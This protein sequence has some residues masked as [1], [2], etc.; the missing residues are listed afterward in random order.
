MFFN[1]SGGGMP[2]GFPGG[3]PGGASGGRKARGDVD[4]TKFYKLLEVDKNASD[5]EIK[6]AYRKLAIKHHPDKGGD[7]EVFKELSKAYEVLSDKD[8]RST[9]DQ[10]GEEG[11]EGG[12]GGDPS[13]I[14]SA[15]FGGGGG[16]PSQG[17]GRKQKT[18]DVKQEL[19]V[20]L[21][22]IYGGQTKKMAITRQVID[23]DK[24]VK[25][26]Q[27][28]DGKGTKVQIVRMGPMI[29]QSQSQCTQ[30]GGQ[31]KSFST[32]KERQILEVHISKGSPEGHQIRFHEMADERPDHDTG[33]VIF[34][35][36]EQEHAVF[37]R[38]GADLFV[39]RTISLADALCGY[40]LDILHLDGRKLRVKTQPGDIVKPL[41][42]A[43]DPSA[44]DDDNK[45]ANVK[46]Q[47]LQDTDCR[48]DTVAQ[49][50]GSDA[51]ALKEACTGQLQR[52]G[53]DCNCFTISGGN[54]A[55]KTGTRE[56]VM[57]EMFP[58][59]GATTYVQAD[60]N[61]D[62]EVAGRIM[63]CVKGEG[64]PTLKNPFQHGNMFI[65]LNIEFPTGLDVETQKTLR[66]LLPRLSKEGEKKNT[67][68]SS[69]V[70]PK[71][72]KNE[73]ELEFHEIIDMDPVASYES[74]KLNMS[75]G[76]E[77]YDEDEEGGRGG[78]GGAQCQQM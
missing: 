44:K 39:E 24:G 23:K 12:G 3:F 73:D 32:K 63:K 72:F 57:K 75:T 47:V 40:E 21:E 6:K 2:G 13:D 34:I 46:W 18:E 65:I 53:I 51:D 27:A 71:L 22:Q 58:K 16:G 17:R 50:R 7:P 31:G 9:Y 1:M 55:F 20:T 8:K 28:C 29:Q 38:K 56:E 30:C 52:K 62:S 25:T 74:N 77:A 49:A 61:S 15:F 36:R 45:K 78:G 60:P 11:L 10:F 69:K 37:K 76:N 33:D 59:K 67:A 66:G 41:T 70:A 5:S 35:V 43:F 48:A 14:F 54:C 42:T 26:C 64:L 4:T 68:I 19:K